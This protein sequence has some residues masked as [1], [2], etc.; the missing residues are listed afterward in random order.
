[1]A[2]IQIRDIPDDVYESIRQEAK[3]AGQSL[4]AYMRERVIQMARIEA[5]RAEIFAELNAT[6][7][8]DRGSGIRR[9]DILAD[10]DETRRS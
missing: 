1:M 3:A 7:A 8:K 5:R 2:T 10:L 6:L 9:E 4:Q